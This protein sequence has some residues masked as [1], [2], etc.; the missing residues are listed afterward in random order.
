ML[1][2]FL[3]NTAR[4]AAKTTY[5]PVNHVRALAEVMPG[6]PRVPLQAARQPPRD[7]ERA[8]LTIRVRHVYHA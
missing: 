1:Q 8:T 6:S 5:K 4:H 2:N 3:R 7:Y